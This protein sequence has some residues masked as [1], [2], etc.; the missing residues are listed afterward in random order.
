MIFQ[1]GMT[2]TDVLIST[3][4]HCYT[5]KV[6][7]QLNMTYSKQQKIRTDAK[8]TVAVLCLHLC[9]FVIVLHRLSC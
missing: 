4:I 1:T 5:L 9:L 3:L 2:S 6:S 7:S 8:Y